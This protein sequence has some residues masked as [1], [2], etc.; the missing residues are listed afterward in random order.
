[1]LNE[2]AITVWL[3]APVDILAE[4]TGR[5]NNRPLLRQGDPAAT[6]AR[7]AEER[8]PMYAEAQIHIRSGNG[9]HSDV[10]D[11]ILAAVREHLGA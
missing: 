8:Q 5:R 10:V 2:R 9:A 7:L 4:R 6:L 1:L 3:V 11:S